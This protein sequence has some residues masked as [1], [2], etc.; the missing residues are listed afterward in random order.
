MAQF[1]QQGSLYAQFDDSSGMMKSLFV[2]QNLEHDSMAC[3]GKVLIQILA[4]NRVEMPEDLKT[5]HSLKDCTGI[6][7]RKPTAGEIMDFLDKCI[8]LANSRTVRNWV[9]STLPNFYESMNGEDKDLIEIA[10]Q[11]FNF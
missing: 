3:E 5:R 1:F 9:V 11:S 7:Y 4:N 6:S 10:L 2:A 8:D